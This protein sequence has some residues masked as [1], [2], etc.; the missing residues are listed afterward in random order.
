MTGIQILVTGIEIA[1]ACFILWGFKNNSKLI[2]YENWMIRFVF[3]VIRECKR[4][5]LKKKAEIKRGEY[6]GIRE[7]DNFPVK[8]NNVVYIDNYVA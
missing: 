1:V 2:R 7:K 6:N 8:K 5:T 3:A 4:K